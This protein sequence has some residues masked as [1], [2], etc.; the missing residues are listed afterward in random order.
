MTSTS[1]ISR[2]FTSAWAP[3]SCMAVLGLGSAG[4]G[5]T[6]NCGRKTKRPPGIG[7]SCARTRE[8]VGALGEKYEGEGARPHPGQ[9]DEG[10]PC[11]QT[12]PQLPGREVPLRAT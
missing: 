3:V 6:T 2:L 8:G 1:C 12:G 5:W 9:Y 4:C 10:K 7:R 11:S